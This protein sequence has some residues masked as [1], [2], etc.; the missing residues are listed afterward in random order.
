M[1]IL[2]LVILLCKAGEIANHI[3]FKR[4][5]KNI[6]I[7]IVNSL[8]NNLYHRVYWVLA[9]AMMKPLHLKILEHDI[10]QIVDSNKIHAVIDETK[11]VNYESWLRVDYKISKSFKPCMWVYNGWLITLLITNR[12]LNAYT[13][14]C[15]DE[16]KLEIIKN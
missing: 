6:H 7:V 3:V 2:T 14:C 12:I 16:W 1:T 8:N 13:F 11:N 10:E 15:L 4:R 5:C 9:Q